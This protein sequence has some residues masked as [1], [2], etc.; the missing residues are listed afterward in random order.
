MQTDWF[1]DTKTDFTLRASASCV[2]TLS[3]TRRTIRRE[4]CFHDT[5]VPT[6]I[7]STEKEGGIST[8]TTETRRLHELFLPLVIAFYIV[9]IYRPLQRYLGNSLSM[10]LRLQMCKS[11]RYQNMCTRIL[12]NQVLIVRRRHQRMTRD[13]MKKNKLINNN[14]SK[15]GECF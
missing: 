6:G 11:R 8:C 2:H 9:C 12:L 3:F 1:G 15:E 5:R 7:A 10:H 13:A 14:M 4:P